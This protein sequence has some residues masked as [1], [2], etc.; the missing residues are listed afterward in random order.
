M[1]AFD[2]TYNL[3]VGSGDINGDVTNTSHRFTCPINISTVGHWKCRLI[4]VSFPNVGAADNSV[5]IYSSIIDGSSTRLGDV[6]TIK[7]KK[8]KK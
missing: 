3:I 7:I 5:F 1:S 6:V 8:I 4:N 2:T